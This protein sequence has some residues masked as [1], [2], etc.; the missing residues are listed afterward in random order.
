MTL[1]TRSFAIVLLL[2]GLAALVHAQIPNAGF[3]NWTAG[4]PDN[5]LT[6]NFPGTPAVTQSA[7]AHGDA[8]AARGEVVSIFS[9]PLAPNLISTNED[10]LGFPVSQRW[11]ELRGWYKFATTGADQ[12]LIGV[13]MTTGDS[14]IGAGAWVLGPSGTYAPFSV[15]IFYIP[16]TV[17]DTAYITITIIGDTITGIPTVGSNFHV[18]DLS[19]SGVSSAGENI[20]GV[21]GTLALMQNY[22]NPFNPATQIDFR[23]AESGPVTLRIF[24]L[25]GREIATLV[26]EE[27]APGSYSR[28]F[29][30]AALSSGIYV[31][32]LTSGGRSETR[33]MAFLR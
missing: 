25:L 11:A 23:V 7:D 1:H 14:A 13:T 31:Y 19:F 9:F 4:E 21:P 18:D 17:P 5:W 10:G 8:S 30:A 33:K 16:S 28:T 32:R 15:P 27:L 26:D 12:M 2:A 22:P 29:D 6:N 24:D 3:E 20:V